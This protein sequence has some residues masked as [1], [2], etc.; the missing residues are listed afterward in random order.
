MRLATLLLALALP[1]TAQEA[2]IFIPGRTTLAP[3]PQQQQ[4]QNALARCLAN[5]DATT[6]AGATLAPDGVV[7]EST[8]SDVQFETLVLDLNAGT[9]TSTPTPPAQ[10][11]NYTTQPTTGTTALPSVAITIE[12]DFDSDRIRADQSGK[13]STIVAALSDPALAGTSYAVIGHTDAKGSAG[14]NCD[15]SLRRAA[16]VTR[17]LDAAYVTLPLY[18]VGFGEHVLKDVYNPNAPANRRV[19]FMRLP[20]QP[21]AVLQ[22]TAAVCRY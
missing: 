10:P 20:D 21:G 9:V 5:P 19:T 7:T 2:E 11:T 22:T 16:S 15:L 8:A 13:L 1:A 4:P 3:A 14:Y 18:P 17:A 12:F 6:C